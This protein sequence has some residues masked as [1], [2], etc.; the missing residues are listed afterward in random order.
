MIWCNA[1]DAE[2]NARTKQNHTTNLG[3]PGR[4]LKLRSWG[5]TTLHHYERISSRDLGWHRRENGRGRGEVK[6]SC[7]FDKWVKPKNLCEVEQIERK[8]TTNMNKVANTP[9]DKRN[10]EH[11]ENLVGWKTKE[12]DC[13]GQEVHANTP[14]EMRC[15]RNDKGQLRQHSGWKW[16]V[17]NMN[18]AKWEHLDE[19]PVKRGTLWLKQDEGG[20]IRAALR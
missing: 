13:N 7:F 9:L 20:R 12:K 14:V 15:T 19:T 6:L 16:K 1:H 17:E 18:L 5:V 3:N 10:K 2:M 11:Y 4:H 8:N